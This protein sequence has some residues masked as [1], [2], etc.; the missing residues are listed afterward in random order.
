MNG[1]EP[2]I[3]DVRLSTET[4][5]STLRLFEKDFDYVMF[6]FRDGVLS[7]SSKLEYGNKSLERSLKVSGRGKVDKQYFGLHYLIRYLKGINRMGIKGIRLLFSEGPQEFGKDTQKNS[8]KPIIIEGRI[9]D[10]EITL[11]Q[12]PRIE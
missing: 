12:A 1:F 8:P 10:M 4:L 11:Y 2:V 3:A 5:L 6:S 7:I 9:K